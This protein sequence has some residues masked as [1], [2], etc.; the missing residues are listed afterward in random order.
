MSLPEKVKD[1]PTTGKLVVIKSKTVQV[2]FTNAKGKVVRM[3]LPE[4][5]MSTRIAH[6]KDVDINALDGLE[7]VF[8]EVQGQPKNVR[9]PGDKYHN[10]M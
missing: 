9:E 8:D 6:A 3:Q 4:Q 5:Q 10:L 2:E 1:M 7:V